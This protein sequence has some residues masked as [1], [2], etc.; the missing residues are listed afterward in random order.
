[1]PQEIYA[2]LG[3]KNATLSPDTPEPNIM[4]SGVLAQA[5]HFN[6]LTPHTA[7]AHNFLMTCN[8]CAGVADLKAICKDILRAC[9]PDSA[10]YYTRPSTLLKLIR[11]EATTH[12]ATSSSASTS[13]TYPTGASVAFCYTN[14]TPFS[15]PDPRYS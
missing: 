8:P 3:I 2:K 1:M 7:Q 6:G 15:P 14:P 10:T 13:T 4:A 5:L 12:G 9:G 11:R